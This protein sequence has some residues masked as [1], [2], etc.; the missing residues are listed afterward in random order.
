MT[1]TEQRID[2]L[3]NLLGSLQEQTRVMAESSREAAS[4]E[5]Q[6]RSQLDDQ[7]RQITSLTAETA[8]VRAAQEVAAGAHNDAL[9]ERNSIVQRLEEELAQVRQ[10]ASAAQSEAAKLGGELEFT[11]RH[12]RDAANKVARSGTDAAAKANSASNKA[13]A[14]QN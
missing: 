14:N 8:A 5:H 9:A 3:R 11:Q 13:A 6:L 12:L 7:H 4:R 10:E 1:A 2:D